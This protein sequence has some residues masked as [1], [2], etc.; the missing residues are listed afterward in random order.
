MAELLEEEKSHRDVK[1]KVNPH[2]NTAV[3]RRVGR[4]AWLPDHNTGL[5]LSRQTAICPWT[6]SSS[7]EQTFPTVFHSQLQ[8]RSQLQPPLKGL[9]ED[10]H[11]LAS[12]QG[13]LQGGL[14]LT[15]SRLHFLSASLPDTPNTAAAWKASA[16]SL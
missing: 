1:Q 9:L 10:Q 13:S 15:E 2:R 16:S 7:L 4:Q 14:F 12:I 3:S 6:R 8:D 11:C 5:L